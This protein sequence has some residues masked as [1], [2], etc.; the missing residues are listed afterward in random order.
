[1]PSLLIGLVMVVAA[2]LVGEFLYRWSA[3]PARALAD[4][5]QAFYYG[6][7]VLILVLIGIVAGGGEAGLIIAG[8]IALTVWMFRARLEDALS[9]DWLGALGFG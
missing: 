3:E 6:V 8:L 1:M 4:L 2:L 5:G 7:S 9:H